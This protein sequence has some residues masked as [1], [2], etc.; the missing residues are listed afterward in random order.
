MK[1]LFA[2][3]LVVC[4]IMPLATYSVS[5]TMSDQST[6]SN[7]V[8]LSS[9]DN[10]E[11]REFL[12]KQGVSIPKEL[13]DIDLPALFADLESN[14]NMSVSL[15]WTTLANFIE[16]VRTVVK[17][18]YGISA[19]PSAPALRYTLQY[20]TLYSWDPN[21]MPYYNCYAY[22]IG[23]VSACNPGDFSGQYYDDTANIDAVAVIVKDDLNGDLGY[24]C[25]KIQHDRPTSTSGWSNVIAVRKD[26]TGDYYNFN[27][28]HFA[29]LSSSNWYHKPGGNAILKFIS[30]PSNSVP[31]T[32]ERYN[33][34]YLDDT[35]TYDSQLRYLLYKP[36][37]G[38]ITY[39]WTGQDYHSKTKHF[40]L[41]AN[42]CDDCGDYISTV[43]VSRACSGPPCGIV[44][45]YTV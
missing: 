26:T 7:I 22:A 44:R 37:H 4:M 42:V 3:L 38:E 14:P 1:R 19:T 41:Y 34:V 31:W 10:E 12:K 40:Y 33:G 9:L 16:E 11:C 17:A 28:Y 13:N 21:T 25:V 8:L 23:R 18:Y 20:S 6:S 2:F 24:D 27:D 29:K 32:N 35:I 39:T 36:D 45:G 15:G 5:A 43:W 30:A